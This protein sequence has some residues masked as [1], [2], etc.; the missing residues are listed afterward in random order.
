MYVEHI[1]VQPENEVPPGSAVAVVTA[2]AVVVQRSPGLAQ[3]G[4]EVILNHCV[5]DRGVDR[6]RHSRSRPLGDPLRHLPIR[7]VRELDDMEELVGDRVVFSP[8]TTFSRLRSRSL[9]TMTK[10]PPWATVC[11]KVRPNNPPVRAKCLM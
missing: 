9:P 4:V 7:Y 6:D 3:P 11:G 5:L 8:P 2:E 10:V 1:P